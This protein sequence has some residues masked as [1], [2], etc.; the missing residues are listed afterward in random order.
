M[1]KVFFFTLIAAMALFSCKTTKKAANASF[2][3]AGTTVGTTPA[4]KVFTVPQPKEKTKVTS[5]EKAIPVRKEAITFT[6]PEE[7]NQNSFEI[8][9]YTRPYV[10]NHH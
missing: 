1:K 8:W 6:Q 5:D 10:C 7:Q 3:P 4:P 9:S 2:E